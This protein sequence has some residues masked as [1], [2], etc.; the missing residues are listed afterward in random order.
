MEIAVTII[1]LASMWISGFTV[2]KL[3]W[4]IKELAKL[5]KSDNLQEYIMEE[6]KPESRIE[7]WQKEERY[8]E[9]SEISD[10]DLSNIKVNTE[11]FN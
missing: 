7:V 5:V 10:K 6:W 9:I 4:T 2:Y 11:I 3:L 8:Q 1:A